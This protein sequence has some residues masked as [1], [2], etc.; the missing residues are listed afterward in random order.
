MPNLR[1]PEL[2]AFTS[3]STQEKSHL[4]ALNVKCALF[5]RQ[6]LKG[7]SKASIRIFEIIGDLFWIRIFLFQLNGTYIILLCMSWNIPHFDND[8][9]WLI[10]FAC[11]ITSTNMTFMRPKIT[12]EI[13]S[14]VSF[15]NEIYSLIQRWASEKENLLRVVIW[16]WKRWPGIV[17]IYF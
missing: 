7:T 3:R 11:T 9:I 2:W 16:S 13:V 14:M 12:N 1:G 4:P 15:H 5:S 10:F 6:V 17:T 8:E